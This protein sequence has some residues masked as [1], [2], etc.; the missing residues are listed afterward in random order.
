MNKI[1]TC[2]LLGALAVACVPAARAD[3]PEAELNSLY[4]RPEVQLAAPAL[5]FPNY[6]VVDDCTTEFGDEV[7]NACVTAEKERA[8]VLQPAWEE[9]KDSDKIG[10]QEEVTHIRHI[11]L[12]RDLAYCLDKRRYDAWRKDHPNGK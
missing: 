10:C 9:Y 6:P 3:V 5:T 2:A 11:Q 12:Y 8:L 4:I 1:I 7:T